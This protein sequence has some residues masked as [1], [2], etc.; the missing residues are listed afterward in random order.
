VFTVHFPHDAAALKIV[1]EEAGGKV[2]DIHGNEQRYDQGIR[3]AIIS[4][5]KLHQ[6]LLDIVIKSGVADDFPVDS[7]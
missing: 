3:G 7:K 2:T 5:G 4:N 6:Q 1:V